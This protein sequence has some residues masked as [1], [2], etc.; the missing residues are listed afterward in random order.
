MP[1]EQIVFIVTHTEFSRVDDLCAVGR[2]VAEDIASFA[3]ESSLSHV[4]SLTPNDFPDRVINSGEPWFVDFFAPWCPPC[5]RLLPEWRK[6]ATNIGQ[7]V[8][9]GTVDCTVH[10]NLCSQMHIHSYPTT[11]FY[12]QSVPHQFHGDRTAHG[13]V[14]FV[15]DTLNPKVITLTDKNF[16]D[17]VRKR[18]KKEVWM[19]DFYA[20]WCGPCNQLMPTW[21]KVG[22]VLQKKANVGKVDCTTEHEVCNREGVQS[23]PTIRLY[24]AGQSG[25]RHYETFKGWRNAQSI[26]AWAFQYL[27]SKVSVLNDNN[28]HSSVLQSQD[29]WLVD[30][31]APWC[32]HCMNF[33]PNFERV[34]ELLEH[35]V[36]CG[37]VDCQSHPS[38]CQRFGIRQYPTV[39]F[40]EGSDGGSSQSSASLKISSQNVNE[41]INIVNKELRK[42]QK[43]HDEL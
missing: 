17:L 29:P 35:K 39:H 32:G 12:N 21:N 31:Y 42:K 18:G 8:S 15:Q 23:Y 40:Y 13:L 20:P 30:F 34:A 9:F 24:P 6:A 37:K 16:D 14:E 27:P 25:S 11:I 3:R 33:A 5:M 4:R 1:T 10:G 38:V 19:V 22:K 28:F 41:I 36:K 43:Q 26:R 7:S 2:M